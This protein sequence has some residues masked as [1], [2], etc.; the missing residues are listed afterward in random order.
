MN[1]NTLGLILGP[2]FFLLLLLL[3]EPEGM[4]P[5]AMNVAAVAALMAVWWITEAI[6]IPAT[7]LLP[8]FLFPIL[9]IMEGGVV[10]LSYANHLI[11]LFM[12]GFL[13]AVTMEKWNLHRRIA[14]YTIRLIGVTPNR[15]IFGFM[16]STWFLSMWISNTATTMMM[17][18]IALAVVSRVANGIKSDPELKLDTE[19]GHFRFG[20]A[21]MLG[22]GYAASIGGVAT[23]I[24][25]PPNAIFAGVVEKTY[26][27]T[28]NLVDWM[29][30]ALPLSVVMLFITWFL[31]THVLFRSGIKHLPGGRET[32]ECEITELGRVSYQEKAVL[33]VFV[34]VAGLW[35]LRGLTAM[36]LF[37]YVQDSTIAMGGAILLFVIPS[38]WQKREFL[39]DWQTAITIPWDILILF[40]GGFALA[41]GFSQSGLTDFIAGRLT[42]LEGTSIVFM[43][44]AAAALVTFLTEITSNTATA[45][46]IL[47]VMAALA[48]AMQ[49]HPFSLMIAATIAASYAFMLPVATPPN[50]IVFGSRQVTIQ[51]MMKIG[52]WLNLI[53]ILLISAAVLLI[54]PLVWNIDISVFPVDLQ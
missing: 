42:V 9:G 43:V 38:N 36:P 26:G 17:L 25:T 14:L 47:P 33:T 1:R 23:L 54:V 39:L 10:T 12:G 22:I 11:Y 27:I 21:L 31:L 45:T 19:A 18:T 44:L 30:F 24:G 6:P 46:I 3:P 37:E 48:A 16:L 15:I 2:L 29:T 53:G 51:Q 4:S 7:A 5:A 34:L 50:A 41:Q 49:V 35:I 40:G 13:I 28:I 20:T 32:I 8:I 52:I